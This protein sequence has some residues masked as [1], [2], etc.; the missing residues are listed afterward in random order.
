MSDRDAA[1]WFAV[2]EANVHTAELLAKG[3]R[4]AGC[5]F[6]AQQAAEAALKALVLARGSAPVDW[7]GQHNLTELVEGVRRSGLAI[8][9]D[10]EVAAQRLSAHYHRARYPAPG[11]TE[12]PDELYDATIAALALED[13]RM[14]VEFARAYL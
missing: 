11:R 5:A 1:R 12:L 13:A 4:C 2:A 14:I 9:A 8:P 6:Y 3:G 10:L 7:T